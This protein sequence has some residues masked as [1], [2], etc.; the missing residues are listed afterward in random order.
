MEVQKIAITSIMVILCLTGCGYNKEI[1]NKTHNNT[2]K[3]NTLEIKT[4]EEISFGDNLEFKELVKDKTGLDLIVP[5]GAE[6][7]KY[8]YKGETAVLRYKLDKNNW[9]YRIT[10]SD[11]LIY[12]LKSDYAWDTVEPGTVKDK[13]AIYSLY[14]EQFDTFKAPENLYEVHLV[15]WYNKDLGISYSLKAEGENLK[16]IDIQAYADEIDFLLTN[17]PSNNLIMY[18]GDIYDKAKLSIQTIEWIENYNNL[19]EIE[20]SYIPEE[21][22]NTY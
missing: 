7:I 9:E 19:T 15:S 5:M 8:G 12:Q 16:G 2:E 13:E 1:N 22:R 17:D 4:N 14:T 6:D 20:Q 3:V 11:R 21:L 18:N 10:K